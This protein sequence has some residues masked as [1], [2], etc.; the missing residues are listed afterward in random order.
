[1]KLNVRK[2]NGVWAVACDEAVLQW[3][4]PKPWDWGHMEAWWRAIETCQAYAKEPIL[5]EI[6]LGLRNAY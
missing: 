3:C 1:M 6:E 4:P 2:R 5:A